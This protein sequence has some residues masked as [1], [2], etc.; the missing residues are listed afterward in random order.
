M[1]G[2]LV[3]L[4]VA[5]AWLP[6]FERWDSGLLPYPALLSA[7]MAIL[8]FQVRVAMDVSRGRGRFA[9]RRARIATRIAVFAR[10]YIAVMALRYVVTMAL[11]PELRWTG[12]AIPVAFHFVLGAWLLVWASR[13][14]SASRLAESPRSAT[15][16]PGSTP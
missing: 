15:P 12:H 16:A 4:L 2:L 1:A 14:A 10:V 7:Q 13:L 6:S 3:A 8:A 5:P 11:V 9:R